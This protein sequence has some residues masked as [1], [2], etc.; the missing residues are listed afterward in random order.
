MSYKLICTDM[1]GTLLK[2]DKQISKATLDTIAKAHE[3]GVKLAITTGR[4]FVS[5]KYYAHLIGVKAP[6]IASNGAYVRDGNNVIYQ[7]ILGKESCNE[8]LSIF[9]KYDL[10][11]HL[12][13]TDSLYTSNR[14]YTSQ[15]Y[16]KGNK[17]VPKDYRIN[18]EKIDDWQKL[19]KSEGDNILKAVAIDDDLEKLKKAKEEFKALGKYEVVS[20]F[21]CNFELMNKE[22]SKGKAVER[23]TKYYN[24]TKDEVIA[25]GDN[26][27]DLSMIEYAGLGV[28]MENGEEIVKKSANYITS[29]NEDDGVRKVIEKFVL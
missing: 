9:K 24:L 4:I 19:I 27:N 20:S 26:E 2:D 7:C 10:I 5:A 15:F 29:S 6:V 8:I 1:D 21:S 11:P 18:I 3:K 23:L 17:L 14:K 16:E 25:I 28:A 13:T 22:V 12:Y